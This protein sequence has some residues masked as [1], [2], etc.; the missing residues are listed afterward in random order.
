[1]LL[2]LVAVGA[3][4]VTG[5]EVDVIGIGTY[6]QLFVDHYVIDQMSQVEKSFHPGQKHPDNPIVR[7]DTP[8]EK[9][10]YLYGSVTYGEDEGLYKMWYKAV[11]A[12]RPVRL[13]GSLSLLSRCRL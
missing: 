7:A 5:Q 1:M 8:W 12:S 9:A 4:S 10:C 13:T 2:A 11:P 3:L 6:P